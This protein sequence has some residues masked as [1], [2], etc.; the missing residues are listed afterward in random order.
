MMQDAVRLYLAAAHSDE[1]PSVEKLARA[2]DV[3]ALAYGDCPPGRPSEESSEPPT[4]D[5]AITRQQLERRFPGLSFYATV[6]P[7]DELPGEPIVGDAIDDIADISKD[8]SEVLWR[9]ETS[10][11]D[12]AYWHFRFLYEVHWG[13]HLH[14]LRSYIH[15]KLH[16]GS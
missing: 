8:L 7:L 5:S 2:L 11:L 10:G 6:D 3:L 12:D 9:A 4:R 14:D 13:R 16:C 1:P 15:S